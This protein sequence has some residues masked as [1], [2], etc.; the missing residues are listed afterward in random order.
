MSAPAVSQHKVVAITYS[1][2]DES[3]AILE[4]SDI[5]V[6]Y[7][8]GGPNDMFPDVEEALDGCELGESVE[9]VLPPEKAFGQH[10]PGMTFTDNINNVPPQFRQIGA[11]VQMQNDSGET[12][13]FIVSKIDGDQLTVDGNHP[14]AGKVLR[15]AVT[16]ADIRDATEEEKKKGVAKPVMH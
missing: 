13:A 12:R 16:V 3:G 10:D 1:I 14:F 11:E 5:P 4:Q 9:V 2:I 8:H 15:Y 7:V 6:Y